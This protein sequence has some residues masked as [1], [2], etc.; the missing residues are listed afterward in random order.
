[1]YYVLSVLVPFSDERTTLKELSPSYAADH[2]NVSYANQPL[3]AKHVTDLRLLQ[4]T[5]TYHTYCR[6]LIPAHATS[7]QPSNA[8][9]LAAHDASSM[10]PAPSR[11]QLSCVYL[12]SFSALSPQI[13]TPLHNSR[14]DA[15]RSAHFQNQY[16]PISVQTVHPASFQYSTPPVSSPQYAN[17]ALLP[18]TAL[19]VQ[20]STFVP[21][22][23]QHVGAILTSQHFAELNST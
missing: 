7:H 14:Y 17:P 18:T 8:S 10:L 23:A 6:T 12:I 9:D 2:S 20:R 1:M 4:E 3:Q 22:I 5:G 11:K 16:R 19:P 13:H 15:Q 21:H